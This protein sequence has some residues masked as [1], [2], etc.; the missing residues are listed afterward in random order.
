LG[1]KYPKDIET[2][3]TK[4]GAITT[5]QVVVAGQQIWTGQAHCK[6]DALA[7]ALGNW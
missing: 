1:N 6:W 2:H 5:W 4:I 7:Q 3:G